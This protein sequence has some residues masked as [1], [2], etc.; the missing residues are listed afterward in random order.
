MH[1]HFS[2][3]IY[4]ACF[5]SH[6]SHVKAQ[7]ELPIFVICCILNLAEIVYG[8]IFC[9]LKFM[10]IQKKV[11]NYLP[12]VCHSDI[13]VGLH[14]RSTHVMALESKQL[15]QLMWFWFHSCKTINVCNTL[16]LPTHDNRFIWNIL[17][18]LLY[19]LLKLCY[20]TRSVWHTHLLTCRC[21]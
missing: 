17:Y 18:N 6:T 15:K 16:E 7:T 10:E 9:N 14:V 20:F 8:L 21:V 19:R 11:E 4:Y 13:W 1:K 2:P 12:I 3:V 5:T